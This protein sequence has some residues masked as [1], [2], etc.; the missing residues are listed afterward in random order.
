[1]SRFE[2]VTPQDALKLMDENSEIVIIDIRPEDD[3]RKDHIPGAQNL[4]YDGHDFQR[5]VERLDRN[6][7][8]LIYCKSGVRSEYFMM[9][10]KESGF[11]DVY[12]I[13]GGYVAWQISKLPLVS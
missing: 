11:N 13:L 3:Y 10:M 4:D 1:M 6:K 7:K 2:L 5:K 9:K 8:Y 12:A